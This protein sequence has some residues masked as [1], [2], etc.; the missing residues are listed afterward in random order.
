MDSD[1]L[2]AFVAFCDTRSFT[3]AAARVGKS[4]PALFAVVERLADAVGAPLYARAGRALVP[5]AAGEALRAH[6][7]EVLAGERAL[8]AAVHGDASGPLVLACGE[9]ALVHVLAPR[10]AGFCE[11]HPEALRLHLGDATEARRRLVAGEAHAAV[12]VEPE[13]APVAA[14]LSAAVLCPTRVQA[15]GLTSLLEAGGVGEPLSPEALAAQPLILPAPGRP[16]RAAVEALFALRGL[17]PPRVAVEARGWSAALAL[18]RLGVGLALVNDVLPVPPPLASR[19]VAGLPGL[20]YRL[21]WRRAPGA[22]LAALIAALRQD[23]GPR[24]DAVPA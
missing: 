20:V 16:L 14:G 12:V 13:G 19:A 8:R 9:G 4:Q 10:L 22:R 17:P 11:R 15:A 24:T 7:L 23:P 21:S 1:D 6:A 5:T 3:H 18:A 2:R